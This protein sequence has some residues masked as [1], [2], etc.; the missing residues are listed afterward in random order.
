MDCAGRF[1]SG[2][3][4]FPESCGKTNSAS[5]EECGS[6]FG[7]L[8]S[9]AASGQYGE[10]A[11]GPQESYCRKANNCFNEYWCSLR[12]AVQASAFRLWGLAANRKHKLRLE[13]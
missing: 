8:R 4:F 6:V 2:E 9:R 13:L 10:T 12:L 5:L 11:R 1:R 7:I 3:S